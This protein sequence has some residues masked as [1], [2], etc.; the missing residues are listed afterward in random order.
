MQKTVFFIVVLSKTVARGPV[1]RV[2]PIPVARGPVPRDLPIIVARGPVP[3]DLPITIAC[4][5]R[6]PAL[7]SFAIRRSQTTEGKREGLSRACSKPCPAYRSA[8]ACPSRTFTASRARRGTGPRPTVGECRHCRSRAPALDP[9]AI[10]RSQTTEGETPSRRPHRSARACPSRTFI[11]SR[12]R[13]GTG[14]RP[15]VGECRH[16][17][18]RAPALDPMAIRRSQT[19]EGK[20]EG[21]SRACSKPCPLTVAR[22]PVPREHSS[23]HGHGGGQAPALR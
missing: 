19:T 7:D 6:A 11:A 8:R 13:R 2:F 20:R 21:L 1:P 18:S 3:R 10:R 23:R 12:A 17:R 4:S 5:S 15:T 9:M 22:G 14:P 16:C